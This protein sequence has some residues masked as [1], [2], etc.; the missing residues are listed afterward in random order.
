M[1]TLPMPFRLKHVH[2]FALIHDGGVAL[3]DTGLNS[4]ETLLKLEN[5]LKAI[6]KKI[7]DVD[8]IF[9]SHFHTDH[10]GIAGRIKELS[11]ASIY[12]S[13]IDGKRIHNDQQK[14][15][16]IDQITHFYRQHGLMEDS[17]ESLIRLLKYFNEVTIPF[18]V[19]HFI[20]ANETYAIGGLTFEVIPA[21]GHTRGQVCFFFRRLGILLSVDHVLPHITPNLAPETSHPEYRPLHSYLNSLNQIKDLPVV[22]VYPSHGESFTD[23]KARIEEIIEH[24]Y[25]RKGL[26]LASVQGKSKTAYHVSRDIFGNNLPE[27]DQ[28]L[29]INETYS[30]L[31]ELKQE[32][33]VTEERKEHQLLYRS[34]VL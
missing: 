11:G 12:M 9:I 1:M 5:S 7:E 28:F 33:V 8:Q 16:N 3:F 13:E 32:G 4:P 30:H 31:L 22:K 19:D 20:K 26:I 15:L 25:E 29:A 27:F 23:L 24:H 10:C 17:I 18:Q 34:V 2:V 6:G 14:G 21:Q